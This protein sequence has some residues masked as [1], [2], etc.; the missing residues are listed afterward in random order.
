MCRVLWGDSAKKRQ[1]AGAHPYR[2]VVKP[3]IAL[4]LALLV[5]GCGG[6]PAI[7]LAGRDPAEPVPVAGVGYRSTIAPYQ[8]RRPVDPA[9]WTEQNQR[10]APAPRQ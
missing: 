2:W 1:N 5:T 3:P 4:A 10:V 8:S 6:I 7:P 9:P